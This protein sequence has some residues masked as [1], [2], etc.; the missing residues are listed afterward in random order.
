MENTTNRDWLA[1]EE[2]ETFIGK[3][4]YFYLDKW[5]THS[6]SKLKGWNWAAAFFSIEWMA[7]RKMYVEALLYFLIVVTVS[8]TIGMTF[9][10]LRVNVGFDSNLVGQTFRILAGIFGNAI[11][12]KKALR[13]LRKTINKSE[14]EK[15]ACL[16][17]K[18]GVS[19]AGV[20]VCLVIQ[21]AVGVLLAML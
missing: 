8:V 4:S 14:A 21:V 9:D 7:Y 13:V 20:V 15:L 3:N 17:A 10:V 11:Y 5:K 2:A 19:I 12:R 16:Q 6:D 18:G 1:K